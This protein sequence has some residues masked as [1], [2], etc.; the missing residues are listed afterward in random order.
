M[1]RTH[2]V[3]CCSSE[4]VERLPICEVVLADHDGGVGSVSAAHAACGAACGP[5]S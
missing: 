2:P 1:N 5:P 4:R 3:M